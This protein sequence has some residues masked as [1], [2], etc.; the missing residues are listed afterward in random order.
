MVRTFWQS[1]SGFGKNGAE[2]RYAPTV[3][4]I[5]QVVARIGDRRI[6]MIPVPD[7][8]QFG[9]TQSAGCSWIVYKFRLG[10]RHSEQKLQFAVSAYLPDGVEAVAEGWVVKEWWDPPTRPQG[11]GFYADD[12]S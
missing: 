5:V 9:N 4:E 10:A 2:W 8:R 12:P 11:D 3:V 1:P 6:Q 7:A